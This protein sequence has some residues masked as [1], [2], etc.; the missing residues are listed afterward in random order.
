MIADNMWEKLKSGSDIRGIATDT[1][2][3]EEVTLTNEVI[4]KISLSFAL[5][6]SKKTNLEYCYKFQ[7]RLDEYC[8]KATPL[9]ILL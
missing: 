7:L 8:Q 5:W 9:N 3:G 6:L 2:K 1:V 4:E